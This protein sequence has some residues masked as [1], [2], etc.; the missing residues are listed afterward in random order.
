MSAEIIR[1][2]EVEEG[3][4]IITGLTREG[5]YT[6]PTEAEV[7]ETGEIIKGGQIQ[8]I[9]IIVTMTVDHKIEAK[10]TVIIPNEITPHGSPPI[11]AAV[12]NKVPLPITKN[13]SC[14]IPPV[15]SL[16]YQMV[17][18]TKI[19]TPLT[20]TVPFTQG[21]DLILIGLATIAEVVT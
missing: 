17:I 9:K 14:V 18:E 12:P 13:V 5:R 19:I 11:R 2:E 6:V 21:N 8:I 15:G 16:L 3:R 20:E 4:T 7:K 10:L 1:Q